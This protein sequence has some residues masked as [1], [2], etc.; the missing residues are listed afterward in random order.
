MKEQGAPLGL[1]FDGDADRA[2][3]DDR[4]PPEPV[5]ARAGTRPAIRRVRHGGDSE[6]EPQRDGG[7][8]RWDPGRNLE[9][10]R[11]DDHR[12]TDRDGG[13]MSGDADE[14]GTGGVRGVCC[15]C[16]G[17]GSVRGALES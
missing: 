2:P 1:A 14:R 11:R 13:V 9:G 6:G 16:G 12:R 8:R 7:E 4:P 15:F 17:T 5:E 10:D 3:G